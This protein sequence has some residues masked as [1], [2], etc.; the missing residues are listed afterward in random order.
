MR[1][2]EKIGKPSLWV[3]LPLPARVLSQAPPLPPLPSSISPKT[4]DENSL[5]KSALAEETSHYGQP[6]WKDEHE[7][8]QHVKAF[9]LLEIVTVNLVFMHHMSSILNSVAE[10]TTGRTISNPTLSGV[11]KGTAIKPSS[12]RQEIHH[13]G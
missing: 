9:H 13:R 11:R 12:V 10:V 6:A 3:T 1:N 2:E 7:E 8:A 4:N 5:A